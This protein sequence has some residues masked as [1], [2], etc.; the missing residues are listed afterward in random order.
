MG[1]RKTRLKRKL[2]ADSRLNAPF[3]DDAEHAMDQPE[4]LT[5][6]RAQALARSDAIRLRI[7]AE[8]A[9][10]K[11]AEAEKKQAEAADKEWLAQNNG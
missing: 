6:K 8:R 11:Q 2:K 5:E 9:A 4:I 10:K 1:Q 7:D 3:L